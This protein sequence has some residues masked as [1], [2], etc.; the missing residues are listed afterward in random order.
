MKKF[1]F[2]IIIII[3]GVIIYLKY[4]PQKP[5][6]KSLP[7]STPSFVLPSNW[8]TIPD[9]KV[10]L[11]LEKTVTQGYIPQ[12]VLTS[13]TRSDV[14]DPKIYV[15]RLIAGTRSTVTGYNTTSDV[16]NSQPDFYSAQISGYYYNQK[17]KI[18]LIERLYITKNTVYTLT[19]SFIGD[20]APEINPILDSIVADKLTQ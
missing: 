7:T 8:K 20:Q 6:P 10:D 19:A 2:L 12:I 11:K 13:N 1:I 9:A 16:R 14:V 15:D 18:A 3:L 5:S 4:R 17:Q